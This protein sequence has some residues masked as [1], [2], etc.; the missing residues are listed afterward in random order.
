MTEQER[1][2][3]LSLA[4]RSIL[5]EFAGQWPPPSEFTSEALT[6]ECGA[7]VTL[8]KHGR[9]RGCI[10]YVE[11]YKPLE[12]TVMEMAVQAAFHDP[13][14]PAVT[15]DEFEDL[16]IEISVMSPLSEVDDVSEIEVGR[17]GLVIRG[18]GRSGLL[19]PQVATDYG[20]DRETFLEH[21]CAKAG[22]PPDAWKEGDVKILK[23]SAEVFGEEQH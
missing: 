11:A 16:T 5:A 14:F 21:T 3:L 7:F 10:G 23:F 22:L 4:R 20:W 2:A 12:R 19:L 15:A 9:L 8:E 1:Q 17:H 18:L 6:V 13:R